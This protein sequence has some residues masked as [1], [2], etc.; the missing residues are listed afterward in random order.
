[1]SDGS[2]DSV[3][4]GAFISAVGSLV[5]VLAFVAW[6]DW[7]AKRNRRGVLKK[8]APGPHRKSRKRHK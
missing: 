6:L 7:R 4:I 1:M 8:R 5:G 2:H 3:L